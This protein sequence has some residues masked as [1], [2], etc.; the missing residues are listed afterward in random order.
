MIITRSS[1]PGSLLL[2]RTCHAERISPNPPARH[3]HLC[4]KGAVSILAQN[5]APRSTSPTWRATALT[6]SDSPAR[7]A[8]T[9]TTT[10]L[11]PTS[12]AGRPQW[13]ARPA[14]Q[15]TNEMSH[16]T[17]TER[18]GSKRK[19]WYSVRKAQARLLLSSDTRRESS[20]QHLTRRAVRLSTYA[21]SFMMA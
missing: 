14:V 21:S 15:L 5:R 17:Q 9:I 10:H 16:Q 13:E 8:T 12:S 2:S 7:K 11:P 20:T 1:R 6:T 4:R 19:L 18:T 3:W